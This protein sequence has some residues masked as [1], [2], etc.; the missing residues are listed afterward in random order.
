MDASAIEH[1]PARAKALS[2]R[3]FRSIGVAAGGGLFLDAHIPGLAQAQAPAQPPAPVTDI[4]AYI[5]IAPDGV[6]TIVNKNPECGQ[7]IKTMLPMLIAEELDVDWKNVRVVQA[8]ADPAKFFPRQVAGG[9]TATPQNW[10][11]MRRVGAAGRAVLVEAAAQ[12]WG[13]PAAECTTM[14]GMVMH[15]AS[16]RSLGY[17]ALAAKAATLSAPNLEQ[18]ALKDPKTF[19]I[20]GK[21]TANV[22]GQAVVTGKPLFGIDITVPGM[23]Y[24]VYQKCRVFGGS[25]RNANFDV[26]KAQ[27]GVRQ[28]FMIDGG[29]DLTGLLSGIAVVADSWWQADKARKLLEVD[30]NEGPTA[31]MSSEGFAK[32]AAAFSAGAPQT[33]LRKDGDVDA[34]LSGAAKV[35]EAQYTYPFVAHAPLEPQNCTA[36]WVDDKVEIWAPTQNPEPGRAIVARTF[37]IKPENVT[38]H[39]IRSG[40]GFG[41]R[42]SNDYMVEAA[43]I[44]KQAGMPVKLVWTRED[45]MAH[46]FYRPGGFHY[47]KGGVD[48][49]GKLVAWKNHFV[50]YGVDGKFAS[51][52]DLGANEFPGRLIPN[53]DTGYSLIPFGMPTGPMRAPRSNALAFVMNCFI[54]ELAHAAGKDPV[55]FHLS[56][57]GDPRYVGDRNQPGGYD[58]ARM[59]AVLQKAAERSGWGRK[60]PARTGLGIAHWFSHSGYFATVV[61]ASVDASGRVKPIKAW[62]VGDV[63]SQ[64]VNPSGAENQAQGCVI[65]GLGQTLGQ[66]ITFAQGRTEQ[67]N[68][69]DFPL[70]RM[71]TAPPVDSYFLISDN[72]PTGIGEPALPP[73]PPALCNAL[74]AATGVRIRSLPSDTALRTA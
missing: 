15:K 17:G 9:S 64:I 58:V 54:D 6:V 49:A 8:D 63:G 14:P 56:V 69:G 74:C 4:R 1:A 5:T 38:I 60:M 26:V 29:T 46:D 62:S 27:P 24:A 16:N 70:I 12:T 31:A 50:S 40:G 25:C 20:I 37:N 36:R 32:Q 43:A 33:N 66:A 23:K 47:L 18:V 39:L 53:F 35:V 11:P 61:E 13:V 67:K 68:F 59:R 45:D 19:H 71:A 21:F 65:D 44:A 57:L 7:G 10:L 55:D 28:A 41:R 51:S 30:W 34:A 72:P 52:A 2:R 42:L 22:D 48:S 73:T 3:G